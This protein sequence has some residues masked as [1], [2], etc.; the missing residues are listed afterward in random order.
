[1]RKTVS[2]VCIA[3]ILPAAAAAAAA[4]AAEQIPKLTA[5]YNRAL[6]A[7]NQSIT[8]L[9]G[10]GR[11]LTNASQ[12]IIKFGMDQVNKAG[13]ALDK[14]KETASSTGAVSKLSTAGK[15]MMGIGG[16][17]M[18]MA[19]VLKGVQLYQY[20]NRTFSVIPTMIVDEADIKTVTTD[21]EGNEVTL[22]NFD[23]FAYYEVVKCNRQEIG[24]HTSAHGGVS[25]YK[26]WGCGDA[27]DIN[28]DVG[29]QWLAIYV[30]RSSAK[31][32]PIL[33]DTLVLRTGKEE[34]DKGKKAEE[35]AKMPD[36]CNGCLHNSG[37]TKKECISPVICLGQRI[38]SLSQRASLRP[39]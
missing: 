18:V 4:K 24:L 37:S 8:D 10:S 7:L 13:V 28:G 15:W 25:D 34:K 26:G 31:G 21:D 33:A 16:A 1:M 11:E 3:T 19:A 14:A 2:R 36:D 35:A 12:G 32:N 38:Y 27:A 17:L 5:T 29:K 9:A 20:Y 22:I 39:Y 6:S 23:Q 30:N